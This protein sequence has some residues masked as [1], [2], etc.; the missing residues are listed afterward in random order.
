MT[1]QKEAVKAQAHAGLQPE[2]EVGTGRIPI[3]AQLARSGKQGKGEK[4]SVPRI[5]EAA[6]QPEYSPVVERLAGVRIDRGE[7]WATTLKKQATTVELA[8]AR[9][10]LRGT[11]HKGVEHPQKKEVG[12]TRKFLK[13]LLSWFVQPD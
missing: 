3:E 6:K 2:S 4:R 9:A 8:A 11:K 1:E 7:G 5:Q 10:A 12:R 13:D